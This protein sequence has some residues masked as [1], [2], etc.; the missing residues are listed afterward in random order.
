LFDRR[1][2]DEA[3]DGQRYANKGPATLSAFKEETK[4]AQGH[5]QDWGMEVV[6]QNGDEHRYGPKRN[7]EEYFT[8]I[9]NFKQ[10]NNNSVIVIDCDRDLLAVKFSQSL[11]NGWAGVRYSKHRLNDLS[12]FYSGFLRHWGCQRKGGLSCDSGGWF[13]WTD[14]KNMLTH[15]CQNVSRE[16]RNFHDEDYTGRGNVGVFM[17]Q[18]QATR[19][20]S[21]LWTTKYPAV[22]SDA[23]RGGCH[24]TV[25]GQASWIVS[26]HSAIKHGEN[27]VSRIETRL[28][29]RSP[30]SKRHSL[31]PFPAARQT[32]R[33][34]EA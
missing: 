21:M 26:H 29:D 25:V 6:S 30:R 1:R 33:D 19:S 4:E 13:L 18:D 27:C 5:V 2:F 28:D 20:S 3:E 9:G 11:L 23:F 7:S 15:G 34:D 16:A 32:Q 10:S 31:Q 24:A 14:M 22:G 17:L 12:R 8:T